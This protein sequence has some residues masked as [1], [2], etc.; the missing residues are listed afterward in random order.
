MSVIDQALKANELYAK[1]YDPK[2]WAISSTAIKWRRIRPVA[3]SFCPAIR[4]TSTGQRPVST[5][6][7]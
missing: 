2:W 6:P 3:S 4:P 1:T 7:R 5:S